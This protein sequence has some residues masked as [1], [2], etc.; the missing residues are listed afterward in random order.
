MPTVMI[1]DRQIAISAGF[2]NCARQQ[3]CC[4]KLLQFIVG[5]VRQDIEVDVILCGQPRVSGEAESFE[6]M[7]EVIHGD[8]SVRKLKLTT[9][10]T[11]IVPILLFAARIR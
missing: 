4:P 9:N 1:K 10:R 3:N 6:P 11:P 7:R 2:M 8:T 5:E